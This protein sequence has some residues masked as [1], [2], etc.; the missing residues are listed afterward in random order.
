MKEDC[1]MIREAVP[2]DARPIE[3]LYRLLLPDHPDIEVCN[4]ENRK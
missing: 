1:F 4:N 2:E 3:E